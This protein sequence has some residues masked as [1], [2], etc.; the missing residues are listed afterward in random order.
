M[1]NTGIMILAISAVVILLL[2]FALLIYAVVVYNGLVRLKNNIDRN[3]SNIDVL[4]K[5]RF[6]ELPKLVKVC[7]RYMKHER[8]TLERVIRARSAI[9]Q[10]GDSD[11]QLNAENMLSGALKSLFAVS[12]RY[13]ELKADA[14]FR[15]L[16]ARITEM[17]DQI[18]DRREFYN[19]SVNIYNIRIDQFPDMLIA[20]PLNFT[21]RKLWE[22][23]PQHREDPG[24]NFSE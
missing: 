17:E 5:Q 12:E 16:Q 22:I 21:S 4:L 13:P 14:S 6:D 7:E 10:A 9:N 19:E 8:E 23:K 2:I 11:A 20:R 3:W 1:E 24:V 18:A 15:Q